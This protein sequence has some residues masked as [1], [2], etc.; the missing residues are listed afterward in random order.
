MRKRTLS[1]RMSRVD[2]SFTS[3]LRRPTI[4]DNMLNLG[5]LGPVKRVGLVTESCCDGV[6]PWL[7]PLGDPAAKQSRGRQARRIRDVRP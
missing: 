1:Q 6:M 5:E 2:C 7:P 3:D 4:N